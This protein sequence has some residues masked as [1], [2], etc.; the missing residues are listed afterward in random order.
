MASLMKDTARFQKVACGDKEMLKSLNIDVIPVKQ[1]RAQVVKWIKPIQERFKLKTNGSS[2]PGNSGAG[3]LLRDDAGNMVFAFSV[4]LGAGS[5]NAAEL[6]AIIYGL[7]ICQEQRINRVELET[8][9]QLV[10]KWISGAKCRVWYLED[11]WEEAV[12]IFNECG[13]TIKHTSFREGNA[14]ADYLAK[15]GVQGKN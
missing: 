5:N 10:I 12:K 13:H 4:D 15:L 14:P 6:R 3:G 8:N 9:S 1:K 11:F 7:K 2:N